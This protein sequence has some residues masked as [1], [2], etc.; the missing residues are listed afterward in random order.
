ML[1]TLTQKSFHSKNACLAHLISVMCEN[2]QVEALT[3]YSF[4]GMEADL[5]RNLAFRARNSDPLATPNYYKILYTYNISKDDYRSG[6]SRESRIVQV[7]V[8]TPRARSRYHHVSASSKDIGYSHETCIFQ[9]AS[10]TSVP[11]LSRSRERFVARRKRAR[12]AGS[13]F[14]RRRFRQS[15]SLRND[16]PLP[17]WLLTWLET[18]R[19]KSDA[20][21]NIRFRMRNSSR[22]RRV[23]RKLST[24]STFDEN[25]QLPWL[26]F[27]YPKTS[28]SW[29][30]PVSKVAEPRCGP[31]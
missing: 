6:E 9:R 5:E 28:Q 3:R 26:A 17:L 30:V 12:L 22:P 29:S 7:F 4:A 27:S 19:L 16:G 13:H 11:K 1:D 25:T 20:R 15:E 2:G 21:S 23:H 8:L 24:L 31:G 10:D 14:S 18:R